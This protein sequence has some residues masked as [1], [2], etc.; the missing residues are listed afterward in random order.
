MDEKT[1]I[2]ILEWVIFG[3]DLGWV[4]N[5]TSLLDIFFST[6]IRGLFMSSL[7]VDIKKQKNCLNIFLKNIQS[8]INFAN[9]PESALHWNHH[10]GSFNSEN[11]P[12][13]SSTHSFVG[14]GNICWGKQPLTVKFKEMNIKQIPKH[15][16]KNYKICLNILLHSHSTNVHLTRRALPH[17]K[18]VY[19]APPKGLCSLLISLA[20]IVLDHGDEEFADGAPGFPTV[21]QGHLLLYQVC[22]WSLLLNFFQL[23]YFFS[24]RISA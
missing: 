9:S 7:K 21:V 8:F 14:H 11:G 1:K 3:D 22:Y 20:C 12:C 16:N 23:S 13:C 4:G 5:K 19:I 17:A 15:K 6:D 10:S 24:S 2:R 18:E